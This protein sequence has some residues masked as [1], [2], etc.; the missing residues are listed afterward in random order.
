MEG[1]TVIVAVI[2]DVPVLV[3]VKPLIFPVPLAETPMPVFELVQENAAP[4][5]GLVNVV[6][7]TASPLHTVLFVATTTVEVGFTVIV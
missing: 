5:V 2:G 6:P 7:G 4:E 3:A 1:V